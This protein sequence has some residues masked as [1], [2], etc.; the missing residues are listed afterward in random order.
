MIIDNFSS[1]NIYFSK[2]VVSVGTFD[3]VHLAHNKLIRKMLSI[4]KLYNYDTIIFTFDEPPKNFYAPK[5]LNILT[6]PD[7]KVS[8]L[9][10]N[11]I[12]YVFVQKFNAKFAGQ[13]PEDFISN[14][15]IKKLSMK[16]LIIGDDHK[17]GKDRSSNQSD[18]LELSQKYN[19]EI[20]QIPSIF[21]E[22]TRV[23]STN[24]RNYLNN[25]EIQKAN[26]LLGYQYNIEGTIVKGNQIGRKMGF[27][28]ANLKVDA[29]KLIPQK[30]VYATIAEIDGK[31]YNSICNIG[32]RPSINFSEEITIE[33][34]IIDFN[35]YIYNQNLRLYFSKKIRDEQKFSGIE[36]LK[37]Q[38]DK[39]KKHAIKHF[40][41]K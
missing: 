26:Q 5:K 32:F 1:K 20:H 17:F 38:I 12:K 11:G 39:D 3:G 19:F 7:E 6:L 9:E 21:V 29:R 31:K 25:G 27:P 30:G 28:T 10:N 8:F 36:A 22:K 2:T 41:K 14:Y 33:V 37:N 4:S 18:M 35:S 40:S 24:I 16:H 34:H 13:S 15:L 23:S